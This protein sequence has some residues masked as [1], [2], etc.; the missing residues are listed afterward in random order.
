MTK[1]VLEVKSLTKKV[2]KKKI[3][4]DVSFDIKKGEIFGL[5]G[6]NGA[7]KTTIIRMLVNLIARSEGTIIINGHDLDRSYREAIKEVGAIIETPQFYS[8]MSGLKNLQQYARMASV[9]LDD[10]RISHVINLVGLQSAIHQKVK[11]YS[12][13]M[14][15]RL[16]IAQ[17]ILHNPALL[18]L[19]EPTNGLDPEGLKDFR[20]NLRLLT[21]GGISVLISSHLLKEMQLLCD[22]Y[23][24]IADGKIISIS[25]MEV[26]GNENHSLEDRFLELTRK[27]CKEVVS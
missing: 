4:D 2:G 5:L 7:G 17:A 15:Q 9:K 10:A 21:Q 3:V 6:P 23:A 19:D 24:I 13:G 22:R 14:R 20:E 11:T 25:D 1:Y 27:D 26:H 16:G 8:Y 18:L 12:L